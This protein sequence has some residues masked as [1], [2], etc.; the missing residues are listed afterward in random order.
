MNIE[1]LKTLPIA[2][3]P[4]WVVWQ[5]IGRE[6]KPKPDKVPFSALTGQAAS[7][8]DSRTWASLDVALKAYESKR[9]AGLGFVL[10]EELGII[11]IDLDNSLKDKV[12]LSWA[13]QIIGQICSYTEISQSGKGVHILVYGRLPRGRRQ[14][15]VPG[16]PGSQIEMYSG[17]RYLVMTG[18][19]WPESSPTIETRQEAVDAVYAKHMGATLAVSRGKPASDEEL[20]ATDPLLVAT[21]LERLSAWRC[22]SYESWIHV[23][24]ALHSLGDMGYQLWDN[25]SR[26]SE[27]YD[28]ETC[29]AKWQTFTEDSSNGNRITIASVY[30]WANE[31]DPN[32]LIASTPPP[33]DDEDIEALTEGDTNTGYTPEK[34]VHE[35]EDLPILSLYDLMTHDWPEPPWI[36]PGILPVGLAVLAGRPKVGKSW[37]ALQLAQAVAIGGRFLGECVERG[38]VLYLALEDVPRRL[39][40]RAAMQGW[41]DIEAQC[42]FMGAEGLRK[43]GLLNKGGGLRIAKGIRKH[44]YR[45]VVVD[46][47]SRAISGDQDS[48]VEMTAALGPLQSMAQQRQCCVLILDHHNKMA[49]RDMVE[50]TPLDVIANILGSISKAGV[51]DWIGGMYRTQGKEGTSLAFTGRDVEERQFTLKQDNVTRCWQIVSEEGKVKISEGREQILETL[52]TLGR[53]TCTELA[54]GLSR[55]RGNV[56]K[57]LSDLVSAGI[58]EHAKEYYWIGEDE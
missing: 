12:A 14:A 5:A 28:P 29:F 47:L 40:R 45:L 4:H 24:M 57:Q 53:C 48:V 50:G 6:N 44:G 49:L 23:G 26:K 19:W 51:A 36:V 17:G 27:K 31:D 13:A 15:D 42:D 7:V 41:K 52:R 3:I 20:R 30:H 39:K 43:I 56:Y 46:T 8:S 16:S 25:W 1:V 54:D 22:D 37:L 35:D 18:D 11:G 34:P 2:T 32:A 21:A 58:V 10:T 38:P 33:V 9:Y 55:N